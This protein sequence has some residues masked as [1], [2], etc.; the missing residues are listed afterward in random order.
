MYVYTYRLHMHIH[1]CM[2]IRAQ[3]HADTDRTG[4]RTDGQTDMSEYSQPLSNLI[5]FV[6]VTTVS[7][8]VVKRTHK[9][10]ASPFPCLFGC[11]VLR[12]A[13]RRCVSKLSQR[14]FRTFAVLACDVRSV[15]ALII[16]IGFGI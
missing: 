2:R 10:S 14:A 4:P 7:I 3:A 16:R 13:E 12:F 8:T 11:C 5:I 6:V 1:M 9:V 15:G